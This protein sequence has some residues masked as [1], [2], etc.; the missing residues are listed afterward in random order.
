[1]TT[2]RLSNAACDRGPDLMTYLY[3][4]ATPAEIADIERH[5][6]EC[7]AC[8]AELEGFQ[9]V[10]ATLQTWTMDAVAPRVQIV[11]KPTVWQAWREFFAVLPLWG[12][13]ATGCAAVVVVLA[14][15][16]FRAT[17]GP[18]GVSVAFGWSPPETVS[19]ASVPPPVT[20]HREAARRDIAAQAATQAATE[21]AAGQTARREAEL[22]ARLQ[23]ALAAQMRRQRAELLRLVG[24]LNREQRLQVA[25]WLQE[26]ERRS[27]P[28]LLDLVGDFPAAEGDE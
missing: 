2:P 17:V 22:E 27:S 5:V 20:P 18:Q 10:R 15:A 8:R 14:L 19:V 3:G 24:R 11:L 7:A 16:G 12:R 25:A 21:A 9:S 4:E 1:M 26:N 28:D 23:A 13:L 6:Q